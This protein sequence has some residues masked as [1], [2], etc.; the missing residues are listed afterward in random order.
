MKIVFTTKSRMQL[1]TKHLK[2]EICK[3]LCL[4]SDEIAKRKNNDL[5]QKVFL[6]YRIFA[7]KYD[8]RTNFKAVVYNN[9]DEFIICFVG[10][11]SKCLKDH[12]A[13][14][15]M[16]FGK[17]SR[18]MILAKNFAKSIIENNCST[19]SIASGH[20]EG[21]SEA[22]F[23]G[24]NFGLETYTYNAFPLSNSLKKSLIKNNVTVVSINN[25]RA[26]KDI[27]SKLFY[28]DIGLTYIVENS[29]RK[30]NANFFLDMK[31]AHSLKNMGNCRGAIPIAVYKKKHKYFIDKIFR[32]QD[33]ICKSC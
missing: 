18:Q 27:V 13:N 21:G 11:D 33:L 12:V 20:S 26:P 32:L 17:A 2:A 15:K 16:G 10:T 31:S 5:G 14:L 9:E 24:L 8:K 3:R 25:Y 28:T 6:N 4:M 23:V 22:L 30:L 7:K 19:K 1:I 29:Q